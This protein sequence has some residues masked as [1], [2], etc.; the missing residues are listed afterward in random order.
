[1]KPMSE[2][3]LLKRVVADT[4]TLTVLQWHAKQL[5]RKRIMFGFYSC[6]RRW[7]LFRISRKERPRDKRLRVAN[8]IPFLLVLVVLQLVLVV[9]LLVV[10]VLLLVVLVLVALL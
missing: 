1:M 9:L 7:R 5:H 8:N 10:L 4:S 6:R 2:S 3:R